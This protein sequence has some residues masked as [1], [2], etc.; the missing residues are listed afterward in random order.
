MF[1]LLFVVFTGFEKKN[2]IMPIKD[3]QVIGGTKYTTACDVYA[4]AICL[5]EVL[6]RQIP[7]AHCS[8]Q[9]LHTHQFTHDVYEGILRPDIKCDALRDCPREIIQLMLRAWT[10]EPSIRPTTDQMYKSL[11]DHLSSYSEGKNG[12]F[13]EWVF[14]VVEIL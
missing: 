5:W 12:A 13:K 8:A 2:V 4:L 14:I 6:T 3:M 7:Y 10:T 1:W 11:T 9:Y